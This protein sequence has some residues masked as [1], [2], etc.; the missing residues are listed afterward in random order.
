MADQ[1]DV[2]SSSPRIEPPQ[3]PATGIVSESSVSRH[4]E[5]LKLRSE[6]EVMVAYQGKID[7]A[8]LR[9]R[10]GAYLFV[11]I[12]TLLKIVKV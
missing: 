5:L 8:I 6:I 10:V 7:A 9:E 1:P 12:V 2:L 3:P 11:L 4:S